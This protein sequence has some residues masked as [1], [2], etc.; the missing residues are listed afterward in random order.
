MTI[1]VQRGVLADFAAASMCL[2]DTARFVNLT[3]STYFSLV[4]TSWNFG[5]PSAGLGNTSGSLNASHR[6]KRPGTYDVRLVMQSELGC[7]DTLVKKVQVYKLPHADFSVPTICSREATTFLDLS[8][9]G[10]TTRTNWAWN[11]GVPNTLTDTSNLQSP[12]YD[13]KEDGKYKILLMVKDGLGC[14]DTAVKTETVLR[15][16]LSAFTVTTD[17]DGKYGKI[18]MNNQSTNSKLYEWDFGNGEKS[19]DENPMVT[20]DNDGDYQIRLVT[21]A[22]NNCSDTTTLDFSFLYHNLFVPNAFS[23]D[24]VNLDVRY[25]KPVGINLKLY[26]IQVYDTWNHLL[27]ESNKLDGRG[28]PLEG[29]DGTFNGVLLPQGVYMWK[30]AAT[31]NDG[32]EWEGSD[33]GKNKASTLGTVTL[34][35]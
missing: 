3:D 29:W 18:Q 26:H 32:K 23:P 35:R 7:T 6:Y 21:W 12:A 17:V 25:F 33:N 5:E 1:N 10:D 11:F 15:S 4:S 14:F 28:R 24:N 19:N 9:K 31:F 13:F 30:V 2:G 27:W 22:A 34:I 16:P 8:K 20:Y